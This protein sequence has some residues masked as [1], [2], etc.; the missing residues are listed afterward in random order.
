MKLV[1]LVH[2]DCLVL[3][4]VVVR[5]ETREMLDLWDPLDVLENKAL[6]Y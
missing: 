3:R 6:L 1:L 2:L 4:V 5:L